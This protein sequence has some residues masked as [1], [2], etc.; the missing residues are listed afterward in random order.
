MIPAMQ[1]IEWLAARLALAPLAWTPL[2]VACALGRIYGELIYL[3][4]RRARRIAVDNLKAAG[5]GDR[6][7]IVKGAATSCGRM[8]VSFARLPRMN[9]QNISEWVRFEGREHFEAAKRRGQGVLMATAHLGNWEL[10]AFAFALLQEPLHIV[11]RPLDNPWIDEVVER[12]RALPGNRIVH[13]RGAARPILRA[14]RSN[15][16]AGVFVDHNTT[17][18]EG[19]RIDFFGVKVLAGAALARL[20]HHSGAA[21]TPAYAVWSEQERRYIL[22]VEPE[23]EMTGD[24]AEDTRRIHARMEAAI[25]KYPD[26]W[27]WMRR[28]WQTGT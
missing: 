7:R 17:S 22:Y 2:P 25:R 5:I 21:V 24:V 20:A 9:R 1:R 6:E 18:E 4:A 10:C 23:V 26:Q 11:V 19:V 13:W 16:A 15:A 12:Y 3:V 28:R 27:I 14:L 8:L